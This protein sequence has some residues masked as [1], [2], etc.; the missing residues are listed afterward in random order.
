MPI[1]AVLPALP[2]RDKESGVLKG[3]GLITFLQRPSVNIAVKV[4]HGRPLRPGDGACMSVQ[5]A[6]FGSQPP[7]GSVA[8]APGGGPANGEAKAPAG[9]S[10]PK[11]GGAAKGKKPTGAKKGAVQ[12]EKLLGWGG[13]DDTH[14]ATEVRVRVLCRCGEQTLRRQPSVPGGD[15]V[16]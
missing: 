12:K 13:Y 7:G 14:K 3:D 9:G 6:S 4:M 10:K 2:C 11:G 1:H 16:I 5:E 15:P 8:G